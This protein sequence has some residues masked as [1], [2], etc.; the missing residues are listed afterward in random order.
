MRY[1]LIVILLFLGCDDNPAS[2]QIEGCTNSS[3]CNYDET[4]SDDD[5]SCKW[6]MWCMWWWWH[7]YR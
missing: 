2:P 5:G 3:A 4:A 7:W 6:G 1:L